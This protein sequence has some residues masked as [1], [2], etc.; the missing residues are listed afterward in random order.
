MM[1]IYPMVVEEVSS[2]LAALVILLRLR[3]Q[4]LCNVNIILLL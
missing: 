4:Y 1:N 3:N 2:D